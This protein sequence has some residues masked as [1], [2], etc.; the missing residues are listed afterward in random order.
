MEAV[1]TLQTWKTNVRTISQRRSDQKSMRII[2]LREL[3]AGADQTLPMRYMAV[4]VGTGLPP[5]C[6]SVTAKACA[7]SIAF[8]LWRAVRSISNTPASTGLPSTIAQSWYCLSAAGIGK[9]LTL[10]YT[11]FV[12]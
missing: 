4:M 5:F 9:E 10:M 6:S 12:F 11:S 1:G 2:L 7:L 3:K 8:I